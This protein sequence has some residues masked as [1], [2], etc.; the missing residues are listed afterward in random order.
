MSCGDVS[1]E[2]GQSTSNQGVSEPGFPKMSDV[3]RAR[4][5]VA[6]GAHRA[7]LRATPP[8]HLPGTAVGVAGVAR[9]YPG[10]PRHPGSGALPPRQPRQALD[11]A[12]NSPKS[13]PQWPARTIRL[14]NTPPPRKTNGLFETSPQSGRERARDTPFV[15]R[16]PARITRHDRAASSLGDEEWPESIENTRAGLTVIRALSFLLLLLLLLF[17]LLLSGCSKLRGRLMRNWPD[18]LARGIYVPRVAG[19]SQAKLARS[20]RGR[21]LQAQSCEDVSKRNGRGLLRSG[22][23][24]TQRFRGCFR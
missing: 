14:R 8:R 13:Q 16:A 15:G 3:K 11:G 22:H 9:S 19:M 10:R 4:V 23:L 18:H 20:A 2:A 21:H 24:G 17:A 7:L 1:G 6:Q 12:Q 5:S